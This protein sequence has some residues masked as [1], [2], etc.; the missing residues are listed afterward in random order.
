MEENFEWNGEESTDSAKNDLINSFW[1]TI[2]TNQ[3]GK[4]SG[5]KL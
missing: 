1:K 3:S 5:T 2:D 4:V